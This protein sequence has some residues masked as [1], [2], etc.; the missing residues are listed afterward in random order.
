LPWFLLYSEYP[1]PRK[2]RIVGALADVIFRQR[3]PRNRNEAGSRSGTDTY[4]LNRGCAF[5]QVAAGAID[6][7][8]ANYSY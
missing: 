5:S 7:H 1:P 6:I 8:I 4:F 3:Q 2:H